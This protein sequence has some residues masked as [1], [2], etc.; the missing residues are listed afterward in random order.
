[1]MIVRLAEV[2]QYLRQGDRMSLT[3][4]EITPTP[5]STELRRATSSWSSSAT[6]GAVRSGMVIGPIKARCGNKWGDFTEDEG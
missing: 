1:M 4:S 2:W 3:R 6:R 5:C